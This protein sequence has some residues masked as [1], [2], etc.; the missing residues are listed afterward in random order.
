M[1]PISRTSGG[2]GLQAE[3]Y[4]EWCDFYVRWTNHALATRNAREQDNKQWD[5]DQVDQS[6]RMRKQVTAVRWLR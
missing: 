3:G 1:G 4:D 2:R 6:R 5:E